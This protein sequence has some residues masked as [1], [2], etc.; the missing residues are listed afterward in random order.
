MNCYGKNKL[1]SVIVPQNFAIRGKPSPSADRASYL[2]SFGSI[3]SE[4]RRILPPR[5]T[6][7][8]VSLGASKTILRAEHRDGNNFGFAAPQNAGMNRRGGKIGVERIHIRPP[9]RC[10]AL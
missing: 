7:D 6:Y 4:S 3:E 2:L 8:A 5:G 9:N 10:L 1:S